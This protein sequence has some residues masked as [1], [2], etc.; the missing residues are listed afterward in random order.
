MIDVTGL[1]PVA[2]D[3]D[4]TD[5]QEQVMAAQSISVMPR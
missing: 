3:P 1:P 4:L 2:A 5:E